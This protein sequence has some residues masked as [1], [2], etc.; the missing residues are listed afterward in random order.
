M[1][2]RKPGL[3]LFATCFNMSERVDVYFAFQILVK[4]LS[5]ANIISPLWKKSIFTPVFTASCKKHNTVWSGKLFSF[6]KFSINTP[7]S[8]TMLPICG[9]VMCHRPKTVKK[10][11]MESH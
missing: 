10:T 1:D 3:T 2:I 4:V 8:K 7:L 9:A 11:W 6:F 5:C